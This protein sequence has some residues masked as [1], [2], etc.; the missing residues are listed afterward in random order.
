MIFCS[1]VGGAIMFWAITEP[2]LVGYFLT[3][4]Q[5]AKKH[6]RRGSRLG[7]GA[8]LLMHWGPNA[9]C[10]YLITAP[11][12]A[13]MLYIRKGAIFARQHGDRAGL[14]AKARPMAFRPLP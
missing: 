13:Y 6:E 12:I 7:A 11:P 1:A 4:P 9:W 10:T 2:S 14:S 8:Y 5:Y 3:P